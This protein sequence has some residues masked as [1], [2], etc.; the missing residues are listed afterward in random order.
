MASFPL[1]YGQSIYISTAPGSW[2][3][4]LVSPIGGA[5]STCSGSV[6][7]NN[8]T[9]GVIT[10]A[11]TQLP[12]EFIVLDQNGNDPGGPVNYQTLVTFFNKTQNS[13]WLVDS[14]C[15]YMNPSGGTKLVLLL[16]NVSYSSGPIMMPLF[17]SSSGFQYNNLVFMVPGGQL[18]VNAMENGA[19]EQAVAVCN[20]QNGFLSLALAEAPPPPTPSPTPLV[21]I[22]PT[23]EIIA[24]QSPVTT[25]YL[26]VCDGCNQIPGFSVDAHAYS[27][28]QQDGSLWQMIN[29]GPNLVGLLNTLTGTYLTVSQGAVVTVQATTIS[30][31]AGSE[32]KA[33]PQGFVNTLTNTFLTVTSG[34]KVAVSDSSQTTNSTWTIENLS[35]LPDPIPFPGGSGSKSKPKWIFWLGIGLWLA[36]M[37]LTLGIPPGYLPIRLVSMGASL[38]GMGLIFYSS[39]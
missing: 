37:I 29:S 18:F 10:N 26:T 38:T 21:P 28:S 19:G 17:P 5:C 3:G 22:P 9:N 2:V 16:T 33:V 20:Q 6:A 1:Q 39:F 32:W 34:N 27:P 15:M 14:G 24:I 7:G 13:F 25:S 11:Q 23:P 8:Q 36:G 4:G 35:P 30:Q 12:D 31:S